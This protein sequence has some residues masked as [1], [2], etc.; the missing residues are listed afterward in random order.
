[1]HR[2][3]HVSGSGTTKMAG[4]NH[5]PMGRQ[6]HFNGPNQSRRAIEDRVPAH[7]PTSA[8]KFDL[9]IPRFYAKLAKNSNQLGHP[10]VCKRKRHGLAQ[11]SVV[12][13]RRET[14][15]EKSRYHQLWNVKAHHNG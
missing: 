4:T 5:K 13:C 8:N 1:V 10:K 2:L 14:N 7:Q 9:N 3:V 6:H 12:T 11:R 15:M